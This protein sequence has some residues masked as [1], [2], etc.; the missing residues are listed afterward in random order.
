MTPLP[1]PRQR[2]GVAEATALRGIAPGRVVPS[3]PPGWTNCGGAPA[4]SRSFWEQVTSGAIRLTKHE[5]QILSD[6]RYLGYSFDTIAAA[7][8]A[9]R[10]RLAGN[11]GKA[12]Q[13]A[14][15]RRALRW[16]DALRASR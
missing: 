7:I 13:R 15:F 9:R 4:A 6:G 3:G 10:Q 14:E 11:M 2:A 12:H 8:L 16:R 5:D 1:I